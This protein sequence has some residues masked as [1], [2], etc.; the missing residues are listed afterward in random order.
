MNPYQQS[1]LKP[2]YVDVGRNKVQI[3]SVNDGTPFKA[4]IWYIWFVFTTNAQNTVFD[5]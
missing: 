2:Y 5:Q 3:K 4:Y 1:Q